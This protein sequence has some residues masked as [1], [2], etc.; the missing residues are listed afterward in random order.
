[1]RTFIAVSWAIL[2]WCCGVALAAEI[3]TLDDF[4]YAEEAAAQAAWRPDENSL[5]VGLMDNPRGGK[6]LKLPCNFTDEKIRRAVYDKDVSVDLTAHGSIC[7]DL[8]VDERGPVGTFTIYF[9]SGDGWYS[10]QVHG[11]RKGWQE[12]RLPKAGFGIEG[13]PAGWNQV[14]RIRLSASAKRIDLLVDAAALKRR[15]SEATSP[16]YQPARGY[17]RLY[18]EHVTSATEGCDFDFL[19]P[20][21]D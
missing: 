4:G 16:A 8:Y 13:T 18:N 15:R 3:L 19:G 2:A 21:G 20:A 14:D 17:A 12:V 5:P 11:P 6:A 7:F 1:M 10:G 9:H